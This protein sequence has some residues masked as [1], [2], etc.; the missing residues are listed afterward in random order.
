MSEKGVY[1]L[2]V[3]RPPAGGSFAASEEAEYPR[4]FMCRVVGGLSDV[5][6]PVMQVPLLPLLNGLY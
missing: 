3:H 5:R 2:P 4:A 1:Y 6:G